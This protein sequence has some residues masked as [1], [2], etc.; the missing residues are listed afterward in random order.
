M[1]RARTPAGPPKTV[2]FD[3]DLEKDTSQS[4]SAEMVEEMSLDLDDA[5]VIALAIAREIQAL[6]CAPSTPGHHPAP[7]RSTL[8][9]RCVNLQPCVL[10]RAWPSCWG[11][12]KRPPAVTDCP[13]GAGVLVRQL[14]PVHLM[15]LRICWLGAL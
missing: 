14:W 8:S 2:E 10:A 15:G 4:V 1:T 9:P 5:A 6:T 12:A 7:S 3:F 11:S 13:C